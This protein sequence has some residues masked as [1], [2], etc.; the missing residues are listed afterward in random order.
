MYKNNILD[1]TLIQLDKNSITRTIKHKFIEEKVDKDFAIEICNL[2]KSIGNNE[3]VQYDEIINHFIDFSKEFLELQIELHKTGRYK[4]SSFEEVE[5]EVYNNPE[6]MGNRYLYGLFLSQIFWVNHYKILIFFEDLFCKFN[7]DNGV[8]LE[9]PT[10]T[11]I[12]SSIFM[13]NNLRWEFFGCDLSQ[14]SI[15]FSKNLIKIRNNR[16]LEINNVN[17]FDLDENKKFDKIICG[18]LLEHLEE[19]EKLLKKLKNLLKSEGQ[20][21][22]TTAIWAASIDHIYLFKNSNEVREMLR[23]YFKIEEELVLNV[24]PNKNP[25]DDKTPIN[26]ACILSHLN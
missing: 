11:G 9:V 25:E 21:F 7:K 26:Y 3:G 1:Y 16:D 10:G 22:L 24:F 5:R 23:K 14:S 13:K 15:N 20:L 2:A 12:Y 18:E 4:Y 17:V 8:F 19:P 6:V